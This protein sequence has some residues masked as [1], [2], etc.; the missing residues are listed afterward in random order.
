MVYD[1]QGNSLQSVYAIGG[2]LLPQC[3]DIDGNPLMGDTPDPPT[4]P[5]PS[6]YNT[7]SVLGNSYSALQGYVTPS[8]NAVWYP[9]SGNDVDTPEEMW[10]YQFGKGLGVDVDIINA[11]SG[12]RVANDSS[13]AQGVE[14]CYIG[15]ATNIGD[16]DIILLM[17]GTND[18]W[19]AI[20]QGDYVYSNWSESDLA[21][22]RG[23]L[24]YLLNYLLTNYTAKVVFLCNTIDSA[25]SPD[26]IRYPTG[27]EY[28]V[29][30]HTVCEHYSVDVID[31][32]V[33]FYGNHPTAYGMKQINKLLMDYFNVVPNVVDTLTTNATFPITAT[34]SPN[35]NTFTLSEAL[36]EKTLYKVEA[37]I[38][39]YSSASAYIQIQTNGSPTGQL[40]NFSKYAGQ[41]GT[42]SVTV[43]ANSYANGVTSISVSCNK[44]SE[45]SNQTATISDLKIY[46]VEYNS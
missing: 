5:S 30:A 46:E 23:A 2:T 19:N 33:D 12:S 42:V 18:V 35:A 31:F 3:Y 10:W 27:Y 4:P 44:G 8:T 21:T 32:K 43:W 28:Y 16:P 24:A 40:C 20:P 11:F 17:G 39:N 41:T 38:T 7:F 6:E 15:R 36:K 34:W 45:S 37:V 14:N 22:F 1:I 26:Q 29:S 9:A 25:L 13:W